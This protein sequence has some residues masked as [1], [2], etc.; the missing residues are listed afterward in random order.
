MDVE[1]SGSRQLKQKMNPH[2]RHLRLRCSRHAGMCKIPDALA[3]R[4]IRAY[5]RRNAN[6]AALPP[7]RKVKRLKWGDHACCAACKTRHRLSCL[8]PPLCSTHTGCRS[9]RPG[10]AR[11]RRNT[12]AQYGETVRTKKRTPRPGSARSGRRCGSSRASSPSSTRFTSRHGRA[13]GPRG[14]PSRLLELY[15]S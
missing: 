7:G 2:A 1:I 12:P 5:I 10:H 3:L 11:N 13:L 8:A 14:A 15:I 4:N 6:K 9:R